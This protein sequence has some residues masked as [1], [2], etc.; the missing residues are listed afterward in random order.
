[1][2]NP[3]TRRW[4]HS[5]EDAFI[6]GREAEWHEFV[7]E[8]DKF[9]AEIAHEI[10][11]EKFIHAELDEEE[12]NLERLR[13]WHRELVS[14]DVIGA[15]SAPEAE[16]RLEASAERLEGFAQQVFEHEGGV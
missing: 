2:R 5:L 12:Q 1:M 4:R 10:R 8:C 14:R 3:E 15:P 7:R 9:D 6:Q 11:T 16:L 13:R